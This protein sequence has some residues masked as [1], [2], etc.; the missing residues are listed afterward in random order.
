MYEDSSFWTDHLRPAG[1]LLR[2]ARS[3]LQPA[4][5]LS[6]PAGSLLQS[7]G[8]ILRPARSLLRLA[9]LILRPVSASDSLQ[10]R[11]KFPRTTTLSCGPQARLAARNPDCGP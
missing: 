11:R 2:L 7:A 3:L 10:S 5:F 9:G 4:G 1:L 8:L 6:R